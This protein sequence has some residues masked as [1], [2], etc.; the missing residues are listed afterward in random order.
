MTSIQLNTLPND[1]MPVD[2]AIARIEYGIEPETVQSKLVDQ[3]VD[4]GEIYFLLGQDGIDMIKSTGSFLGRFF[5]DGIDD[6]DHVLREGAL[7]T[8]VYGVAE[9]Q[10]D[11]MRDKLIKAGATE[12]HYFG[13]HTYE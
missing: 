4:A 7:V 6:V 9:D 12:T 1:K 8:M 13:D 11:A 10:I 5:N 3:G 2:A